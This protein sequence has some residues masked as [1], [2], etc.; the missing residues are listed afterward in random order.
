MLDAA[1]VYMHEQDHAKQIMIWEAGTAQ[2]QP[3]TSGE[4]WHLYPDISAD[5]RQIAFVEGPDGDHLGIRLVNRAAKRQRW[6][7]PP[8]GMNLHPRFSGDAKLLAFVGPPKA[9][10]PAQV[11]LV[12]L[13]GGQRRWLESPHACYFP[14]PSS[15]GSFLLYQG[16]L[17]GSHKAIFRRELDG[18]SAP[19]A[20]TP[21]DGTAM[22]PSLSFDDA[23]VAYTRKS[24]AG[25]DV[26]VQDLATGLTRQVTHHA[27]KDYAP[28]FRPDGSLIFASD[29]DG[30]FQLYTIAASEFGKNRPFLTPLVTGPGDFYAP[31]SAGSARLQQQ[32]GVAIPAP[33][34]SS[35]GAARLGEDLY[36]VGGHQGHEHTYPPESFL[37]RVDRYD[38]RTASW[39]SVAARPAQAHGLQVVAWEG[40]LYAFGGFAYAEENSPHWRSLDRIDRYD[41]QTDTWSQVGTMPRKR[42]SHVAARIGNRVYLIGGWD[43]TPKHKKDADGRFHPEIDVFDLATGKS[44]TLGTRLPNPLRRAFT[45]WVEGDAV[46][47]AGGIGE[48]ARHF[49]L[50]DQVTRFEPASGRFTELPKLPFAAF[51]PALGAMEGSLYLFGGMFKGVGDDYRYVNHV[52]ELPLSRD[53][54]WR[55]A[56]RYLG[57]TKGFSQV[58]GTADG[59]LTILGGHTY[60]PNGD[61]M[62]VATV[63]RFSPAR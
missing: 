3:L 16:N 6:L 36:V 31:Q 27:A 11:G 23:Q 26:V 49:N 24:V 33:G 53:G 10:A 62:P 44:S 60:A 30:H 55:H 34:R 17:D 9:G 14:A 48:G 15:D 19:K 41:P 25:W 40:A 5:G 35:F 37:D 51:A 4:D 32:V 61:D 28:T 21:L 42:S 47:L 46:I 20:L 56:G 59:G 2:P 58:V 7:V 63:E 1:L 29:R 52:F 12:A 54:A 39:K 45:G 57:E 43:S 38:A 50:L 22:A 18:K 13:P 8:A